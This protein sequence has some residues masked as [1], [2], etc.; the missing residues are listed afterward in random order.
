M[1]PAR[2]CYPF[3]GDSFGGSH[4]SALTLIR[5]LD[6]QR[7]EPLIVV[8]ERGPLTEH[9][10]QMGL[11]YTLLPLRRYVGRDASL[12]GHL[13]AIGRTLPTLY[14]F[15]RRSGAGAVHTNDARMHLTWTLPA[16]LA[17]RAVVWHERALFSP[18]RLSRLM[19]AFASRIVSISRFVA[20]R[21]PTALNQRVAVIDNPFEAAPALE[22]EACRARL[23]DEIG[24]AP[25][26]ALVGMFG[27]LIDW[28][29]PLLFAEAAARVCEERPEPVR[30]LVFG[31]DRGDFTAQMRAIA[32]RAG[33][34]DRLHFMG[35]RHPVWPHLCA[36]D[37]IL[38]PAVGE[39]FGRT[40]VEAMLA[41]TAVVASDSGG[42]REIVSPGETGLLVAPEDPDA[43]AAAA[44]ELLEDRS[45][46]ESLVAK[47][48]AAAGARFGAAEHARQICRVYDEVL[49]TG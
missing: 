47:A 21:L 17:R 38:A 1:R 23:L 10:E 49:A 30:F 18:S 31:E 41:G 7:F 4:I 16:R 26:T 46:R 8:H 29:R 32:E 9:L 25:E 12:A 15:L 44:I 2:I 3:V 20:G 33:C 5:N 36:C 13:A 35:F 34:G 14:R 19:I 37:L 48:K 22:R 11:D 24:A 42:H 45:R 39:P 27:N 6:R 43:F 40:L 28:K